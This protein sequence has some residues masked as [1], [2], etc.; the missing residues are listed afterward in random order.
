M[1]FILACLLLAGC[2]CASTR[3]APL[4]GLDT[5]PGD[6]PI[7]PAETESLDLDGNGLCEWLSVR[8]RLPSTIPGAYSMYGEAIAPTDTGRTGGSVYPRGWNLRRSS[9]PVIDFRCDSLGCPV[10]LWVDG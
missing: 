5:R 1:R 8:F 10:E 2:A 9:I 7:L 4:A 3:P 6:G